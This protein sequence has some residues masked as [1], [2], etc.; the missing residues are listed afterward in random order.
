M[1]IAKGDWGTR[2]SWMRVLSPSEGERPYWWRAVD[3]N[4][5]VLDI[6]VQ[7]RRN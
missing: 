1:G 2:G 5:Q 7:K 6:L 3:Q 4:E